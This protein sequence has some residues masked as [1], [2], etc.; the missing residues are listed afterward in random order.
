MHPTIKN[1]YTKVKQA[2]AALNRTIRQF[3]PIGSIVSYKRGGAGRVLFGEVI[4]HGSY[5]DRLKV[6]NVETG[7]E[8]WI[9]GAYITA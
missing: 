5:D 2:E 3:C 4:M 9:L 8:Y 1:A 6:R 7:A